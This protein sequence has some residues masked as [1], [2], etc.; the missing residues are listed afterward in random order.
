MI[1]SVPGHTVINELTEGKLRTIECN[2]SRSASRRY[3]HFISPIRLDESVAGLPGSTRTVTT[4]RLEQ[5]D[6]MIDE[7]DASLAVMA[8]P[9]PPFPSSPVW[10]D[11]ANPVFGLGADTGFRDEL[12]NLLDVGRALVIAGANS[13]ANPGAVVVGVADDNP[14]T[15]SVIDPILFSHPPGRTLARASFQISV[16]NPNLPAPVSNLGGVQVLMTSTQPGVDVV[17]PLRTNNFAPEKIGL[18]DVPADG[19]V[20][21]SGTF[22][23]EY[24]PANTP[25]DPS[26]LTATAEFTPTAWFEAVQA[27]Q[28]MARLADNWPG[29][30]AFCDFEQNCEGAIMAQALAIAFAIWDGLIYSDPLTWQQYTV[31]PDLASEPTGGF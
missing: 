28:D 30:T 13:D 22:T 4:S 16:A 24:D 2:R 31:P 27:F 3:S 19:V 21:S 6:I 7:L 15:P 8:A 25:F 9:P 29:E 23:V 18:S 17:G 1:N 10:I 11:N 26:L 14:S 12:Q 20:V 5:I